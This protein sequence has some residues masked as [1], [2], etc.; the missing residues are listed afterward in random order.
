MAALPRIITVDPTGSIPQQ[1]RAAFDLMDIL[2]IQIDVP[3][4][5]EALAELERGGIDTVI[6][7]WNLGNGSQG[8]ELAAQ[9]RK[10]DE[11]VKIMLLG[12]Y[13]D[14]ELDD[15]M[16]E[17]SPF[18]YLKRP[19]NIPQLI[20]VLRTAI[21]GGDIFAAVNAR[22]E[23]APS[24]TVNLGNV[25]K[26]NADK[27]DEIMQGVIYDLNPIAAMLATRDG[28][29]VVGRTTMGDVDYDYMASL[30]GSTAKMNID[31]RD[32]IGG[33]LQ[34]LQLYDG[35]DYDVFVL[36]VGLHHFLTIVFDGKDG[37]NQIGAVRRFG[38][39]RAEDLIATI[40]PAAFLVQRSTP[41]PEPEEVR[42]K[43]ERSKTLVTQ[44]T[45]IPE[46]ARANLGASEDELVSKETNPVIES[47]MP[48]L[49]A[50]ADDAFDADLLFGDNFDLGDAD[51]LF[52]L[53][54][55]EDL[56]FEDNK[57]G[58]IGWDD[59]EQLGIIK[60]S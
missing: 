52:S 41:D 21:D 19:F 34:T 15:E 49:D 43:S 1:I 42:R 16:R 35:S 39:K 44:E 53:E 28:E 9:L 5:S 56:D 18:V 4:P 27:A 13:E 32:V 54:A 47:A 20:K 33:N 55:L 22:T 14:T 10:V 11:N 23:P 25:P 50:I 60:D 40:G 29:I 24:T 48:K 38:S 45:A 59:A 3:D 2:V 17:Q 31:M 7:A 58:T 30:I 37:A 26:V 36:S 6:A 46:L 51:D 57:K 8:W 12:D